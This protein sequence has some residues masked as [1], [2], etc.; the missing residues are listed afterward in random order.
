MQYVPNSNAMGLVA[1]GFEGVDYSHDGGNTWVS[2]SDE[3][4]YSIRFLNDSVAYTAGK[5][6]LCKLSFIK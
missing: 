4:F 1:V 3:G 5:G 6:K 2:L